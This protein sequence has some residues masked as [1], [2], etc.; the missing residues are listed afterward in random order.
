ML[1]DN[2]ACQINFLK[3][4]NQYQDKPKTLSNDIVQA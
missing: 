2:L 4:S 1:R 3:Y